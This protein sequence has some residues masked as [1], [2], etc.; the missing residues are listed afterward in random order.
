MHT[1]HWKYLH[2]NPVCIL[3]QYMSLG[4]IYHIFPDIPSIHLTAIQSSFFCF[5]YQLLFL[6]LA[7]LSYF[8][9]VC[10]MWRISWV[11]NEHLLNFLV[12]CLVFSREC[13]IAKIDLVVIYRLRDIKL[14][15][16]YIFVILLFL[17]ENF[18]FVNLIVTVHAFLS[19]LLPSVTVFNYISILFAVRTVIVVLP[20]CII[21]ILVPTITTVVE[22]SLDL[23][24]V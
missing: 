13:V 12:D 7:G 11:S 10:Y 14:S 2:L 21:S 8:Q 19:I 16:I 5:L 15:L 18:L 4:R 20:F 17:K 9:A 1:S 6:I 24:H 3:C 23:I 22:R